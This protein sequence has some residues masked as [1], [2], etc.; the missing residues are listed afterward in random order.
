LVSSLQMGLLGGG[1]GGF[2]LFWTVPLF[3]VLFPASL[4]PPPP[5]VWNGILFDGVV[6]DSSRFAIIVKLDKTSSSQISMAPVQ[7]LV[8]MNSQIGYTTMMP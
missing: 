1:G 8:K 6:I 2:L 7:L 3:S 5:I 4:P